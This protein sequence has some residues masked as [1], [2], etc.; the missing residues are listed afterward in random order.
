MSVFFFL[1]IRRP[2][3]STLFPYTT[4]FRSRGA[5]FYVR[6]YVAARVLIFLIH[7]G[8][9]PA[10]TDGVDAHATP[11][12][13]GGQGPR[14]ADK[15]VLARVVRCSVRDAEQPR[16][17]ADIHDAPCAQ[18]QHLST[19]LPARQER[20]G[21][22]HLQDPPPI[23]ERSVFGGDYEAHPSVVDEHVYPTG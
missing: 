19:E 20:P 4:L 2:P 3:R 12:P 10:G 16:H 18:P 14:Q 8:L 9:D 13:L 1:L 7:L 22:V 11:A 15:A 23:G 6:I 17:R 21:K 5:A